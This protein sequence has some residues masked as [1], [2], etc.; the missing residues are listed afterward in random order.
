MACCQ[1]SGNSGRG[2]ARMRPVSDARAWAQK[3]AIS[4]NSRRVFGYCGGAR[5]AV[6]AWCCAG[7]GRSGGLAGATSALSEVNRIMG[8]AGGATV[9]ASSSGRAA[10]SGGR[11][12]ATAEFRQMRPRRSGVCRREKG[13]V[14][15]SC[16]WMKCAA[17]AGNYFGQGRPGQ[18][19]SLILQH[20]APGLAMHRRLGRPI[21][22][23]LRSKFVGFRSCSG[24][25]LYFHRR[26]QSSL[27]P[28]QIDV[29]VFENSKLAVPG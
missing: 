4:S 11:G 17:Q 27:L 15:Q 2:E 16:A 6:D 1:Q 3:Y 18:A 5:E 24:S 19:S 21:G 23:S 14:V 7:S 8:V 26:Y 9:D 29:Q 10:S 20:S 25:A 22:Q 28:L 13:A 12:D